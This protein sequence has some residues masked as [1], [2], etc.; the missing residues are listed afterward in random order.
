[1]VGILIALIIVIPSLWF[2]FYV[3]KLKKVTTDAAQKAAEE[4]G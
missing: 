2:L 3:F 1:L 4:R